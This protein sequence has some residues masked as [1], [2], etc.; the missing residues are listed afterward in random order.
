MCPGKAAGGA[1]AI[2]FPAT[3][4]DLAPVVEVDMDHEPGSPYE[5]SE[6]LDHL[7]R[8]G[9]DEVIP[10]RNKLYRIRRSGDGRSTR[11]LP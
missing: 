6:L 9:L 8:A 5:L 3:I 1:G 4:D 11:S 10:V 2:L 7:A